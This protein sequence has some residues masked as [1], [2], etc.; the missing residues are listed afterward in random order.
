MDQADR[1][2]IAAVAR[3]VPFTGIWMTAP[4]NVL[5]ARIAARRGM[6]RMRWWTWCGAAHDPGAGDWL[7]VDMTDRDAAAAA[8]A[9]AVGDAREMC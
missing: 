7:A 1:A 4:Q 6:H 5:E 2:A 9:R 3:G 8:L